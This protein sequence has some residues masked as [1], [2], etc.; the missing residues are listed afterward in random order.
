[1]SKSKWTYVSHP[2]HMSW[3][4][5]VD[6]VGCVDCIDGVDCSL[7]CHRKSRVRGM[8]FFSYSWWIWFGA[9][10]IGVLGVYIVGWVKCVQWCL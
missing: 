5:C 3:C 10:G 8:W 2:F 9:L 6:T 7:G 1:M 4:D